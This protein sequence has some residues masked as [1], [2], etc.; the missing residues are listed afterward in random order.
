MV[1]DVN[2][3]VFTVD[4]FAARVFIELSFQIADMSAATSDV[5]AS[6]T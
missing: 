2:Y 6:S 3:Y 5:Y 1:N 4:I